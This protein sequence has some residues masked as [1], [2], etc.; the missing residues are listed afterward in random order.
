MLEQILSLPIE[1]K[2]GQLFFIGISG[3]EIDESSRELLNEISPGGI[4]LFSRNIRE[5]LQTR[6]LLDEIREIISI[7]P[8]LSIDQEGG[9]VDRLRRVIEPMPAASHLKTSADAKKLAKITAE[10]I[11]LLGF[12]MNFAP[13]VDVIDDA[14][15]KTNNGLYSRAFGRSKEAVAEF[16]AAYL[17]NLEQNGCLGCLKHFPGLGASEVDSHEE[18]PKVNL[19]QKEL[20]EIDLFPYRAI[21]KTLK[22]NVVMVAHASFPNSDLQESDQNGK[23]L[24]S[25]LSFNFTTKL[26]RTELGFQGIAIT[27]DLEMGAILKNYGVG[28]ACT[29][30]IRAGQDMLA[31]CAKAENVRAGFRAV[32][33]AVKTGEIS[34]A[35]I[36]ESLTRIAEVKNLINS[37]LPFNE[38]RLRELSGEIVELK[39]RIDS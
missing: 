16:A 4:C 35:R 15:A 24:P 30:A 31:I 2:I 8:F 21:F 13:V 18:L 33:D 29:R 12:N 37:P 27:D 32:S 28:E 36:D 10:T 23:L 7:E 39:E 25:S 9:P 22:P 1:K 11:R 19:S 20:L 5:A 6:K 17:E 14:R 3:A 26:L 38:N 34:E